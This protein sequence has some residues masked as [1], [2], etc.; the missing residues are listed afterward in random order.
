MFYLFILSS[1]CKPRICQ[2]PIMWVLQLPIMQSSSMH[3]SLHLSLCLLKVLASLPSLALALNFTSSNGIFSVKAS[4]FPLP[5][6]KLSIIADPS[7]LLNISPTFLP[8]YK[9]FEIIFFSS[10]SSSP[11]LLFLL[12]HSLH[13]SCLRLQAQEPLFCPIL[14]Y[15]AQAV[16]I[17]IDQLGITWV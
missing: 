15:P 16:G 6:L 7:Q 3:A 17:F 12:P 8:D 11:L 14:F 9:L 2:S 10:S 5:A 4:T 13:A 1:C